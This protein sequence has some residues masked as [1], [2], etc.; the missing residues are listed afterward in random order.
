M[1]CA[2]S[3]R[4]WA[5]EYAKRYGDEYVDFTKYLVYSTH[6]QEDTANFR[7]RYYQMLQ[8]GVVDPFVQAKRYAERKMG[9][10]LEARNHATWAESPTI[11][12]WEPR[13]RSEQYEYTS[14]FVWSDTVH[15]AAARC[16]AI[17]ASLG[18][19]WCKASSTATRGY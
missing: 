14:N 6:G 1:R 3:P 12:A 2:T 13:R 17:R 15:Q 4:A 7:A 8:D 16:A 19:M 10:R 18:S 9:Q 11:D 5:R